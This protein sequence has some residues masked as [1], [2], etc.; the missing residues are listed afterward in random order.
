MK[1]ISCQNEIQDGT[2]NCPY[3]GSIQ[4]N[5]YA[6]QPV[7][8]V[9][10]V[11]QPAAVP[12]QPVQQVQVP[13]QPVAVPQQ[14]VAVP[15]QPVAVPQ[16]PVDPNSQVQ[17]LGTVS[18]RDAIVQGIQSG[19]LVNGTYT[20]GEIIGSKEHQNFVNE[21][22][23]QNKKKLITTAIIVGILIVIIIA[24]Y[25][26][27]NKQYHT[28][29][30]RITTVFDGL[31]TKVAGAF[32]NDKLQMN[33]GEYKLNVQI[34]RSN[35]KYGLETSGK[36]A[37]DLTKSID[38]TTNI[39][40]INY[41]EELL[42]GKELNL[43]LYYNDSK[44]YFNPQNFLDKYI[45]VDYSS[46]NKY[47]QQ[48]S[49]N[50]I[51][52]TTMIKSLVKDMGVT[53]STISSKQEIAT[54]SITGKKANIVRL[55]I[56]PES[57]KSILSRYAETLAGDQNFMMQL[58]ALTGKDEKELTSDISDW[59]ASLNPDN[60][61]TYV[62]EF[63]TGIWKS[64]FYG[65][66]IIS[67]GSKNRT[68]TIKVLSNGYVI[69]CMEDNNQVLDLTYTKQKGAT[70][71][72]FN[73]TYSVSGSVFYDNV[74]SNIDIKFELS[75]YVKVEVP[76]IKVKDSVNLINV[77]EE[78]VNTIITKF[79]QYPKLKTLVTDPIQKYFNQSSQ[80]ESKCEEIDGE[81]KCI[82]IEETQPTEED[83]QPTE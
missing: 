9:Q 48:I 31:A 11:Q 41:G 25:I 38:V 63:H 24:G 55:N 15:Q 68:V 74:A 34:D 19:T 70:S 67:T 81:L 39:S 6:A 65:M 21:E 73:T 13:P 40:K 35:K 53:L 79:D 60:N 62:I 61:D 26:F 37:Y 10:P 42:D 71:T 22:K 75:E 2:I 47:R 36:F 56:A 20:A 16:Q 23:K 78:D 14:P 28:A 45:Y 72:S 59:T 54:S 5:N 57:R 43:E 51:L 12:Q 64:E 7:Q 3:C 32:K 27:Y 18:Q 30:E 17:A 1:C 52:Y 49:Q 82:Q 44:L 76:E 58:K 66:K 77:T 29:G 83:Q 69:R 50:N 4:N 33:S 8:P 46:L 80:P